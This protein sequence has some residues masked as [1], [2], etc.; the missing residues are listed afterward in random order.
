MDEL[1]KLVSE[2]TGLSEEMST[3]AVETVIEFLKDRLPAPIAGQLE[4]ILEGGE[5]FSADD[6]VSGLSGLFGKN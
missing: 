4:N 6:L 1:I 5:D 2:R 3:K